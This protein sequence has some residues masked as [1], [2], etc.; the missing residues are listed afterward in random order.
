MGYSLWDAWIYGPFPEASPY[1][2][3]PWV[4]VSAAGTVAS[5]PFF[6]PAFM[7]FMEPRFVSSTGTLLPL[8]F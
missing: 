4:A 3:Q 6:G 5:G 8:S 2:V 7:D 1:F